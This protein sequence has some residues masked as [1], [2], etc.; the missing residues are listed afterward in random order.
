MSIY[1]IVTFLEVIGPD[2][3]HSQIFPTSDGLIL[4]RADFMN[5]VKSCT[6]FYDSMSECTIDELNCDKIESRRMDRREM[7]ES[8]IV[9]TISM[10]ID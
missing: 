2:D 3:E 5:M 8:K 6:E 7:L 9:E 10:S 1:K 4:R